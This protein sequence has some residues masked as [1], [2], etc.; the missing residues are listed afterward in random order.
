MM[1]WA[2]TKNTDREVEYTCGDYTIVGL[3]DEKAWRNNQGIRRRWRLRYRGTLLG[4]PQ[5]LAEAKRDA[6]HHRGV[7]K[8]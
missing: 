8:P 7:A 6:E 2:R 3:R 4:E 5:R 1:E